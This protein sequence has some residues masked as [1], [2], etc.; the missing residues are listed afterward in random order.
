MVMPRFDITGSKSIKAYTLFMHNFNYPSK[1]YNFAKKKCK[2]AKW[3][4]DKALQIAGKRREA[5][6]KGER[7]RS[8]PMN[9]EF[10]RKARRDK[11]A[12]LTKQ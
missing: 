6:G 12:F 7:E 10:Q 8:T 4:S 9:A 2:K 1:E 11:K 3:L 5:K